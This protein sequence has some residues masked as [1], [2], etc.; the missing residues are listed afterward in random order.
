MHA[1]K[2]EAIA[3]LVHAVRGERV[4]FDADL[5]GLYGVSTKVLNQAVKR[6]SDRFPTDFMFRLT[7][8]EWSDLRSQIVTLS[9]P[10]AMRSQIV[11]ASK[12]NVGTPPYAFTEQGVAMLSSV[13][14]SAR[15][16]EV[17]SPARSRRWRRSTTSSSPWYSTPSNA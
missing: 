2:T 12:R 7:A 5:A 15:A 6:N 16:V 1:P 13:L 3:R 9:S 4:L 10:A 11:T 14:R 17:S 8:E